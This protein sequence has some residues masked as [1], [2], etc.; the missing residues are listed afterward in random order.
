M[1]EG[2]EQHG[3]KRHDEQ[4]TADEPQHRHPPGYEAGAI[5]QVAQQDPIAEGGQEAGP[6]QKRRV[7]DRDQ[8]TPNGN[9]HGG[10]GAGSPRELLAQGHDRQ[11]A[12]DAD[13][14]D[15]RFHDPRRDIAKGD[16]VVLPLEERI[17]HDG[18][19][20]IGDHQ[21]DFQERPQLHAPVR[22]GTDDVGGVI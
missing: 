22:A 1:R 13:R 17:E 5:H 6:E 20:D 2:P 11:E 7:M 21:D 19:P 14:D 9:E 8:R 15:G 18:G 16:D 10:I 3:D 12:E 4:G